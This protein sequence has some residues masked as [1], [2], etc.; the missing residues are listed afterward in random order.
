M[1]P[2][3]TKVIKYCKNERHLMNETLLNFFPIK[4]YQMNIHKDKDNDDIYFIQ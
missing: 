3:K 1:S 2:P 4:N